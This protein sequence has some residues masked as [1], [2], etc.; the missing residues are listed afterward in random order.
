MISVRSILS[1]RLSDNPGE[2]LVTSSIGENKEAF[3]QDGKFM[4]FNTRR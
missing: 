2:F 4:E 3:R 1:F